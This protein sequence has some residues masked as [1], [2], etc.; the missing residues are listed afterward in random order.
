MHTWSKLIAVGGFGLLWALP[1]PEG[2]SPQAHRLA[3]VTWLMAVLW[4]SQALP[5][6]V[7]SLIPL[8]AYPLLGIQ[9]AAEVSSAYIDENVFLFLG[10]FIIALGVEKWGL[11]R[12]LAL[13]VVRVLGSGPRLLVLGFMLAT[14][15]LSMWISNTAA[16]L[17]MLPIGLAM[18]ASLRDTGRP[19]DDQPLQRLAGALMLGIAYAASIGGFTTLVGTP[20]NVQFRKIWQQTFPE[21][22][23]LSAGEWMQS[24]VPV[25]TAFLLCAWLLLTWG[26]PEIESV[27]T[28]GRRVFTERLRQLGPPRR[29]ELLMLTV[30]SATALL[31]IFRT[32]LKIGEEPLIGGWGIWVEQWLL[33]LGADP[34]FAATAVH[35][36]TVAILMAVLMFTIPAER[37]ESGRVR[38][39]MDWAT[40]ETL[41]WGILLLFGGGF[42][43]AAA[44]TQTGFSEWV[45]GWFGSVVGLWPPW[46][47]VATVCLLMT[48]LT[49][50]TSNVATL[51]A[52][53]PILAATAVNIGIDPRLILLPAAIS[54]SCAF[55]LPIATPP[56][57]IVFGSGRV[58][59]AEMARCGVVLNLCGVALMTLATFAI[60]VPQMGID[61]RNLPPW[62]RAA[63]D[64]PPAATP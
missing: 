51:S 12:R 40:A 26:L 24:F 32:P 29:P 62:S 57:A 4:V 54:T 11:H 19:G 35:D 36:S 9:T 59:M 31:W 45:G 43:I 22:P 64:A 55:M 5:I 53:M 8:V 25:G 28:A 52:L 15:V 2:L 60:L 23:A 10:G 38:F 30:F 20:T 41:P 37:D 16:T 49:E 6:A 3:A 27:R 63:G 46:A 34:V 56:N 50:F 18:L 7:T 21:A 13:H 47:L 33:A 17:L 39:L 14:A 61:A 42:A 1:T 58:Q 44:C 48:F